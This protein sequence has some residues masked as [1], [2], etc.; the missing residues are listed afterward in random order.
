MKKQVIVVLVGCLIYSFTASTV[1]GVTFSQGPGDTDQA[2]ITANCTTLALSEA[3]NFVTLVKKS[4][5]YE[6]A[7]AKLAFNFWVTLDCDGQKF[8]LR[9]TTSYG[10]K[11]AT[12]LVR[13]LLRRMDA[14]H[15]NIFPIAGEKV[16]QLQNTATG[17]AVQMPSASG[18]NLC[19]ALGPRDKNGFLG[20]EIIRVKKGLDDQQCLQEL[21][22]K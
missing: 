17:Q 6:L 2:E 3:P 13:A 19:I 5:V 20:S 4:G 12:R 10:D 15:L 7:A 22:L 9:Y 8:R 21:P 16:N 14:R 18:T 11:S 1:F